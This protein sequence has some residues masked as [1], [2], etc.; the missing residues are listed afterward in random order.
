MARTRKKT[1]FVIGPIGEPE[2]EVR[3]AADFLLDEIVKRAL[4]DE[5]FNY[6]VTRADGITEP[7]LITDQ[8][9]NTTIDANLVVADMTGLNPNALYEVAIRHMEGKPVVHMIQAGQSLPFDL[10]DYRTIAYRI[11]EPKAL[12]D[13]REQLKSQVQAIEKS[14]YVVSGVDPIPWTAARPS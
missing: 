6:K 4:E 5:A 1:C 13:A 9:I 8:V 2:T 11:N 12:A 3:R 7:G 14:G 10:K